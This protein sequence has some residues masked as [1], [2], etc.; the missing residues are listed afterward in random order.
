MFFRWVDD[1]TYLNVNLGNLF[2]IAIGWC[3]FG[4]P[5]FSFTFEAVHG[6]EYLFCI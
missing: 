5:T 6:Q 2:Y 4:L 1:A 3:D